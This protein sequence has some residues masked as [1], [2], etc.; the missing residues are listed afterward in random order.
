MKA[1]T[2]VCPKCSTT[3]PSYSGAGMWCT[4]C[5]CNMQVEQTEALAIL[6]QDIN[7]IFGMVLIGKEEMTAVEAIRQGLCTLRDLM[8]N[9]VIHNL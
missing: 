2:Y 9:K 1:L 6:E 4:T 3:A 7:Q 8:S 5:A